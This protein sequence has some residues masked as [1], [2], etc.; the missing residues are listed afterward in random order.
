[1]TETVLSTK[2]LPEFLSKLIPTEK[3]R[4][5]ESDGLIQIVLVEEDIDC[6]A[7]GL[8]GMLAGDSE[9]TVDKFLERKRLEKGLEL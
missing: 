5:K 1:M 6:T 4:V 7:G 9:M 2:A 8:R 3:V